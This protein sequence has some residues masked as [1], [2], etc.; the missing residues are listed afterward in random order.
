MNGY[1]QFQ[2]ATTL[3]QVKTQDV[4]LSFICLFCFR[5]SSHVAVCVYNFIW[6]CHL[7]CS[8]VLFVLYNILVED[9]WATSY[10]CRSFFGGF[11]W[12]EKILIMDIIKQ[13][14]FCYFPH[15]I[16]CFYVLPP[17]SCTS[18]SEHH[19]KGVPNITPF[20]CDHRWRWYVPYT[21]S[22]TQHG[23]RNKIYGLV[24]CM[25]VGVLAG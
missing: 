12:R 14:F 11:W 18:S 5:S 21:P 2:W 19:K 24:L 16:I 3:R 17:I 1:I 8:A 22:T 13:C 6:G 7:I 20:V 4:G 9:I 25:R 15:Y 23:S 10:F